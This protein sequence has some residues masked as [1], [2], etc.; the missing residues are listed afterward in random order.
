MI[1]AQQVPQFLI[2]MI[3]FEV[4]KMPKIALKRG[5]FQ[6]VNLFLD[7]SSTPKFTLAMKNVYKHVC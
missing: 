5:E 7:F 2:I 3:N 1:S 4:R 6:A